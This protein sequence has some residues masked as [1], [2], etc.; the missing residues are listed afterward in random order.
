MCISHIED[1]YTKKNQMLVIH[2]ESSKAFW[3]SKCRIGLII[4]CS[5]GHELLK[6]NIQWLDV[7]SCLWPILIELPLA[8]I[9]DVHYEII[10]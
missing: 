2:V 7:V 9:I 1:D 3:N 6:N 5:K 10:V 8:R 4:E